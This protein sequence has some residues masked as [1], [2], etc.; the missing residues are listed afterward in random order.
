MGNKKHY[1]KFDRCIYAVGNEENI[2]VKCKY[3][4]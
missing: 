3:K 4:F 1:Y 2:I